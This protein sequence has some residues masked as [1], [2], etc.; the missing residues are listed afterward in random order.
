[1]SDYWRLIRP[2]IVAL[3]LLAMA[4][5]AWTTAGS[6][7]LWPDLAHALLGAALVIAGAIALNQRLESKATQKCPARPAARCRPAA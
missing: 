5:S 3:V 1:M 6:P 4:V 2:R 7:P